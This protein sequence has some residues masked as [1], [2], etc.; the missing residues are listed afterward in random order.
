MHFFISYVKIRAIE[1]YG[2]KSE[3]LIAKKKRGRSGIMQFHLLQMTFI[4]ISA[5]IVLA[6]FGKQTATSVILGGFVA[7]IPALFFARKCFQYQGA[8]AAKQILKAFYLGEAIKL[9]LSMVLFVLV[10][11]FFK[12]NAFV[13]FLTYIVVITTHWLSPLFII[14]QQNRPEC[15]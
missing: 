3:K 10:F 13:F 11:I 15:D 2:F 1:H 12:V 9:F 5:L 7:V 6:I 8:R 4:L 14:N